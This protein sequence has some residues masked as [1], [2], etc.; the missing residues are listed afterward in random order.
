MDLLCNSYNNSIKTPHFMDMSC[1]LKC[2]PFVG[3]YN[4]R[5]LFCDMAPAGEATLGLSSAAC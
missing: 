5:Y 4:F 1:N 2:A 3:R